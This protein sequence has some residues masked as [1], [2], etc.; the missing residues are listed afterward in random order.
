MELVLDFFLVTVVSIGSFWLAGSIYGLLHRPSIYFPVALATKM[1]LSAVF[2][3]LFFM[4]GGVI[5]STLVFNA[6]MSKRHDYSRWPVV[7][8]GL[9]ISILC[10]VIA[11]YSVFFLAWEVLD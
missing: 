3:S 10:T 11:L 5:L 8:S 4:I 9:V 7:F 1:A 2:G 6:E